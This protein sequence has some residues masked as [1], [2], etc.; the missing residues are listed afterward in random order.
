MLLLDVLGDGLYPWHVPRRRQFE[1][2][3]YVVA[4][5]YTLLVQHAGRIRW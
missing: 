1:R 2:N 5:G 4:D 3:E